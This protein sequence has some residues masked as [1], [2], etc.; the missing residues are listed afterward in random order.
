MTVNCESGP[1]PP[2]GSSRYLCDAGEGGSA[3]TTLRWQKGR[4]TSGLSPVAAWN[5]LEFVSA[6][7]RPAYEY[8]VQVDVTNVYGHTD[9]RDDT[10]QCREE[11]Q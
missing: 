10:V 1:V 5:D 9:W 11:W 2:P 6:V 4:S 3:V 7:V 8:K